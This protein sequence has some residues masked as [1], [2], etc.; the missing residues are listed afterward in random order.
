VTSW[1]RKSYGRAW[2]EARKT[3]GLCMSCNTPALPG[4][5][6]CAKHTKMKAADRARRVKRFSTWKGTHDCLYCMSREAIPGTQWCGVCAEKHTELRQKLRDKW[7][8]QGLCRGC[9]KK[10]DDPNFKRCSICR[11]KGRLQTRA[12]SARLR[13]KNAKL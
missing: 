13:S 10:I 4:K 5:H 6:L 1:H 2:R 11:E 12:R 9:G 3:S 7:S 8:E